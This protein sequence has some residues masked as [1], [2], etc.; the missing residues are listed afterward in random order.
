MEKW[1]VKIQTRLETFRQVHVLKS[2]TPSV[3]IDV[4]EYIR[5]V[6]FDLF[7]DS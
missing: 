2:E 6:G 3:L 5:T 7:I 4:C 1:S